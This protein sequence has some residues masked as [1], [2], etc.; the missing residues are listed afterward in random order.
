MLA[1]RLRWSWWCVDFPLWK[2]KWVGF[3]ASSFRIVAHLGSSCIRSE[4][5][6]S[7]GSFAKL[8]SFLPPKIIYPSRIA[9]MDS[10]SSPR[11]DLWGEDGLSLH[12]PLSVGKWVSMLSSVCCWTTPSHGWGLPLPWLWQSLKFRSPSL[13]GWW[14]ISALVEAKNLNGELGEGMDPWVRREVE[15]GKKEF[16]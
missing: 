11:S 5:E 3:L 13:L 14:P 10:A 8:F 1:W 6:R 4:Y 16:D 9:T 12:S 7:V 15:V 2:W